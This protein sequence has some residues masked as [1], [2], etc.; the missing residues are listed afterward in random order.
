[1]LELAGL[2]LCLGVFSFLSHKK[3]SLSLCGIAAANIVG[4][5]VYLLGGLVAFLVILA[6]FAIAEFCT[7]FARKRLGEEH[8]KRTTSNIFGNAGAAVIAL[9][10]GQQIAFF[11]AIACALADTVSSEIGM[12]SKKKPRLI[13]TWEEVEAGT[14]GG[15]TALGVA[16][17]FAAA[18]AI[19][20]IYFLFDGRLMAIAVISFAGVLGSLV[21]SVLGAAFERE[22][23]MNNMEVNFIASISGA[24]IAYALALALL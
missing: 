20:L 22:G 18:A 6:F 3:E 19:A 9:V 17:G 21:D 4:I 11:G 2:L 24:L 16:A 7:R 15:I 8:G 12:L 1:M 23:K 5:V 13:T 10:L 14:D